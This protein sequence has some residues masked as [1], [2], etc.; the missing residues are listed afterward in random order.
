MLTLDQTA[1]Q[2]L[3]PFYGDLHNHCG[4]SY[5]QGTLDAAL[6]NAR[7]QLDF[8][9]VTIHAAWP[10]LP[11][12]Q[13]RLDYLVD[14]HEK[15][16]RKAQ[17]NW[18][19]YL[20]QMEAANQEGT[21]VTYPSFEWHSIKYGDHCI[22]YRSAEESQIID[23]PNLPAMRRALQNIDTPTLLIPHHIGYKQGLRGIN[24]QAFTNEF[25]P[26]V[27]IFS[28][29]G[30]SERSEGAYPYLHSMG[31][32]HEHSTAQY[33]WEQGNV[34]GVIGSTDHHNA[35]PGSYGYGRLGVW[36]ESLS[37][38]D[39]WDAIEQRRTYALSGDRIDLAFSV[40]DA[41]MG[42]II[43]ASDEREIA[44]TVQGGD[45]ID[46][47][48]VL[49][50]NRLVHRE[51]VFQEDV[52]EGRFKVYIEAGWGEQE[53]AFDWNI[54]INVEN[55]TLHDVEPRFRG[56]P[57]TAHP[58][59]DAPF[60]YHRLERPAENRVRFCTH[61]HKNL[62]LHTPATEGVCLEIDGTRETCLRATING[63]HHLFQ[64]AELLTGARSI[65]TDGFVSP[66]VCV[67]RAVPSAEFSHRFTFSH[68]QHSQQRDWYTVRVKQHNNQWA[69]S[70]PVW[71]EP[72]R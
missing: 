10:D 68:T 11:T 72:A 43:P 40:N 12:D 30:L 14:Y 1:F 63:E 25:S 54:A 16:F 21:F 42:S 48:D 13:P 2:N 38:A 66:A 58:P 45:S 64:L 56:Q 3:Q 39:I 55:G 4:L 59:E 50:N 22:Y 53:A 46:Y 29:H 71:V 65:Y 26:V 44:V 70:S 57:P 5:G 47:I 20:E 19:Q 24:W 62:S 31:P 33:G 27:E 61:T 9:S 52:N 18:A 37:R 34:F 35:M 51:T 32:R 69:W 17:H 6:Q 36:A 28:F 23:A 7:Q 60:A 67:H 15:G 49:H 41:P 8:V